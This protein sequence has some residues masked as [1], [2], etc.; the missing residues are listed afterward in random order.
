VGTPP[1]LFCIANTTCH[2]LNWSDGTAI[3]LSCREPHLEFP[4]GSNIIRVH[5]LIFFN[6]ATLVGCLVERHRE[7]TVSLE[8]DILSLGVMRLPRYERAGGGVPNND[9]A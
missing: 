8:E 6:A 5:R 9:D 7:P 4:R 3:R 1:T 2:S